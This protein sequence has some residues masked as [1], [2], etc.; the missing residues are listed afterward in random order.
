MNEERGTK[1]WLGLNVLTF[2][3]VTFMF[4]TTFVGSFHL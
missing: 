2:L 1:V 3:A 4:I